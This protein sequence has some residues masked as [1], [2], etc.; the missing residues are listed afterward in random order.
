MST[1]L[2]SSFTAPRNE[3]MAKAREHSH[4]AGD[5]GSRIVPNTPSPS[6]G[7][8]KYLQVIFKPTSNPENQER[9]RKIEATTERTLRVASMAVNTHTIPYYIQV[10]FNYTRHFY[11][12]VGRLRPFASHLFV[13][14]S[15]SILILFACAL[16]CSALLCSMEAFQP[17]QLPI[18]FWTFCPSN[19]RTPVRCNSPEAVF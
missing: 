5:G 16:L 10:V 19:F 4:G 18:S 9:E 6:H 12:Y 14:Q 8:K 11:T 13:Q 2:T 1:H 17:N 7:E 3:T 15:P